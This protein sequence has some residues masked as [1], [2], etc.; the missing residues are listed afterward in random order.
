MKSDVQMP[1][2]GF[3]INVDDKSQA[4]YTYPTSDW[5]DLT[6]TVQPGQHVL[7][8]RTWAP[9]ISSTSSGASTGT[10]N[11]DKVSFQPHLLENFESKQLTWKAMVFVGAD[12]TFD[13]TNPHGGTVSL[14]S[15]TLS[16]GQSSKMSFEFT[17]STKGASLEFWYDVKISGSDK[18]SFLID[19]FAVLDVTSNTGEWKSL[20]K[21]LVPGKHTIEWKFVKS[22]SGS[23]TVWIDDI[24]ILPIGVN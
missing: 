24:R 18:F 1:Y 15:P 7:M 12:W 20:S 19:G 14:R 17:T 9:S 4:G 13:T 16:S 8:F 3:Y 23:S 5:R 2:S 6:V 11:I 10:V 22:G 21:S